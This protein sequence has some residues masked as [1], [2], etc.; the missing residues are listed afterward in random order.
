MSSIWC[1]FEVR[2]IGFNTQNAFFTFCYYIFSN[3][4][5]ITPFRVGPVIGRTLFVF[6]LVVGISVMASRTIGRTLNVCNKTPVCGRYL[7]KLNMA[8]KR[9]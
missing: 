2:N 8:I 5:G 7:P 6:V 9:N 1:Y 4:E 3:V